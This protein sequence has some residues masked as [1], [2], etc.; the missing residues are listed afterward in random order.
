MAKNITLLLLRNVENLGIVGDIVK[1]KAGYARNYLLPMQFAEFPTASRIEAL[2]DERARA[3]AEVASLRSQREALLERLEGV[4]ITMQRSC[5][6][7]GVLYGSITQRDIAD[8]LQAEGYDV[9]TRSIRLRQS[10]RRVGEYPVPIQFDKDLRIDINIE[11][12]A[13][14][15][16]ED[17]RV[18]ME[19]DDEGN[20]IE[21]QA[22]PKKAEP[23]KEGEATE[24]PETA[25]P[26]EAGA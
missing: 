3:E 12:A 9:G 13:D 10:L 25:E 19:F 18:D 16:L 5:N 7:Q 6:D 20:L 1:V 21:P 26:A 14:R 22:K 23:A 17:E 11:V 8:A 24:T 15:S 4:A 2:K